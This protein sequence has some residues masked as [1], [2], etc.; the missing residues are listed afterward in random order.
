MYS[1]RRAIVTS[2]NIMVAMR[3]LR[4][5]EKAHGCRES[6][7]SVQRKEFNVATKK[8]MKFLRE[9]RRTEEGACFAFNCVSNYE[10]DFFT[11]YCG[12]EEGIKNIRSA[13]NFQLCFI[14]D[15]T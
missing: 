6:T 5:E 12:F 9:V 7:A 15:E 2:R 11:Q 8:Y 14:F 13:W 10:Y 4:G 1:E 3:L